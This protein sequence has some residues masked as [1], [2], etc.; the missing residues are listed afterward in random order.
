[1]NYSFLGWHPPTKLASLVAE[2]NT[3]YLSQHQWYADSKANVH[4]TSDIANLASS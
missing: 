1:M 2:P 3:T 4:V